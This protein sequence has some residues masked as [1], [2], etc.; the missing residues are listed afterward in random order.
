MI[1]DKQGEELSMPKGIA[2]A[3]VGMS[4]VDRREITTT[5]PSD[6]HRRHAKKPVSL[7]EM[8]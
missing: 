3:A 1:R 6:G 7:F 5:S 8:P 2:M 4:T